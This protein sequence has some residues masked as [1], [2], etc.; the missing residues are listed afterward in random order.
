MI[1]CCW[2]TTSKWV[3]YFASHSNVKNTFSL[4]VPLPQHMQ[5]AKIAHVKIDPYFNEI[6]IT[7]ETSTDSQKK[8]PIEYIHNGAGCTKSLSK[9]TS[10]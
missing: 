2:E 4:S 8:T 6:R 7:G 1:K 3:F 5:I 10:N 9:F